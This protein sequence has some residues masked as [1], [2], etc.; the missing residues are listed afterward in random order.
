MY[1]SLVLAAALLAGAC[2][3]ALRAGTRVGPD[4]APGEPACR[5]AAAS[6]GS[7]A[8]VRWLQPDAADRRQLDDW[9]RTVGPAV[10]IQ[11]P[12]RSATL[13]RLE[14]VTVVTWNVDVGG[15]DLESLLHD[16]RH[17]PVVIL[18][19]EAYRDGELVPPIGDIAP[20]PGRIAPSPP[21]GIRRSIVDTAERHGLSLFYVPSMRNGRG[22]PPE[23]RGNAI[24]S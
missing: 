16:L 14:D 2:G 22:E 21:S 7:S 11:T 9:C 18:V 15:G 8:A 17:R 13:P 3:G 10:V 6:T 12:T 5:I 19:Q 23:D 1:R 4:I 24:L 20:A